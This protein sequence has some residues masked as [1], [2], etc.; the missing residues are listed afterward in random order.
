MLGL[1]SSGGDVYHGGSSVVNSRCHGLGVVIGYGQAAKELSRG[2]YVHQSMD[3]WP[4]AAHDND[5]GAL[6]AVLRGAGAT[7]SVGSSA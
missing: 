1:G 3:H 2:R 6:A 4:L 7:S 5:V